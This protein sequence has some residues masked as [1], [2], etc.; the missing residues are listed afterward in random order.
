MGQEKEVRL[1]ARASFLR[2]APLSGICRVRVLQHAG[3]EYHWVTRDETVYVR[4]SH[5]SLKHRLLMDAC[6]EARAC[7]PTGL[8][9]SHLARPDG[10]GRGRGVPG[11]THRPRSAR[12]GNHRRCGHAEQPQA[13]RSERKRQPNVHKCHRGF[14]RSERR[15][16]HF[17]II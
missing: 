14:N 9:C 5:P 2:S 11:V 6:H 10:R 3:R 15:F 4:F 1:N 13:W 16:A 8:P 17:L 7:R 12:G